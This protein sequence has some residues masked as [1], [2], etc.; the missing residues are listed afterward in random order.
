MNKKEILEI[1]KLLKKEDTRIDRICGCYV[2]GNKE[3]VTVM[4]E[5]FL[6]LPEEEMF[7]YS[8]L[9]RKSL[10]GT[11]GRNL[12]NMEF[13]LAEEGEGG[14]QA[15]LLALLQ[16]ELKEEAL[17]DTFEGKVKFCIVNTDQNKALRIKFAVAAFPYIVWVANG[18][19]AP[20][21]DEIVTEER[22]EERIR[23]VLDGGQAPTTRPL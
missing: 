10:S 20:L 23:F 16:S 12:I 5:A 8:D 3:K 6:S 2:D 14:R 19:Q 22:L 11:L 7:K 15:S 1:R 21:F 4:R 18:M 17:S 13:P 9:F